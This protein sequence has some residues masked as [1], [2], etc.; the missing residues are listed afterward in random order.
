VLAKRHGVRHSR[1]NVHK[2][3]AVG[4]VLL[5][6]YPAFAQQQERKLIDRILKPD[7]TLQN[8]AQ[9]K[10]F[11]AD[12]TSV[13]KRKTVGTYYLEQKPTSKKYSNTRDVST[14]NFDSRSFNTGNKTSAQQLSQRQVATSTYT[15]SSANGVTGS[16]DQNKTKTGQPYSG[17]RRF[18][19]QGKSQKSLKRKNRPMTIDEVRE[20]LNKNK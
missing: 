20:L 19:E 13:N 17:N 12:K 3:L 11:K 6:V 16:P 4:L 5:A 2:L 8:D 1:P 18:A 9:N 10:K 7:L 14:A 15:A